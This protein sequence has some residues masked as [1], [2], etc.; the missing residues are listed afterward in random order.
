MSKIYGEFYWGKGMQAPRISKRWDGLW[1]I[2][3]YIAFHFN[4][5]R[6]A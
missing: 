6:Y 4:Y 3:P 1:I 2:L 5:K